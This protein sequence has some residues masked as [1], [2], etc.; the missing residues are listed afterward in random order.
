MKFLSKPHYNYNEHSVQGLI[1]L[2][3]STDEE[4][5]EHSVQCL[6]MLYISTG[7]EDNEHIVQGLIMLYIYLQVKKILNTVYKV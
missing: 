1:M 2:Y 6:I 3:I 4:D 5:N 7:E